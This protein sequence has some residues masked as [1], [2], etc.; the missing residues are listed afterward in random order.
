MEVTD[1]NVLKLKR[2]DTEELKFEYYGFRPF[3]SVIVGYSITKAVS[4]D[5]K[6]ELE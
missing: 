6:V 3:R 1:L 4:S 5:F 2:Y